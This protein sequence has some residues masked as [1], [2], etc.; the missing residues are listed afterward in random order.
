[1]LGADL[2]SARDVGLKLS[3]ML[4]RNLTSAHISKAARFFWRGIAGL[5]IRREAGHDMSYLMRGTRTLHI[6]IHLPLDACGKMIERAY[7][8]RAR[9]IGS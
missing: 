7:H 5:P 8:C 9:P 2:V 3:T 4:G 1:M 6:V